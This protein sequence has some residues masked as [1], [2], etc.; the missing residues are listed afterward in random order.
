MFI[1]KEEA[2]GTVES[3]G[4]GAISFASK[5]LTL[6]ALSSLIRP[7]YHTLCYTVLFQI[8]STQYASNFGQGDG[9]CLD[10]NGFEGSH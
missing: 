4:S 3:R 2:Q 1:L 8:Q 10:E 9:C 6:F 5:A 7:L